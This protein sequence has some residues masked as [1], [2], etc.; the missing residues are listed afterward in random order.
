M[1]QP[2]HLYKYKGHSS[3]DLH[4]SR[5]GGFLNTCGKK[6]KRANGLFLRT[7]V[8]WTSSAQ[9]VKIHN[10]KLLEGDS[11]VPISSTRTKSIFQA[12]SQSSSRQYLRYTNLSSWGSCSIT[13][14]VVDR[15]LLALEPGVTNSNFGTIRLNILGFGPVL[16]LRVAVL[17]K[18][19]GS[20]NGMVYYTLW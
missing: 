9:D 13:Q 2:K 17:K 7:P 1:S 20:E 19:C 4:G 14:K 16:S 18:C 10:I 11:N 6:T 8:F 5:P 3:G 12:T 15:V